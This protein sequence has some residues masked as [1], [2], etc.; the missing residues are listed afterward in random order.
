MSLSA[1]LHLEKVQFTDGQKLAIFLGMAD[2][3]KYLHSCRPKV[4]HRPP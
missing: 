4:V 2:G 3:I 1:A